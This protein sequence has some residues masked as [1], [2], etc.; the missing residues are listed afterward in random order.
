MDD[1]PSVAEMVERL[2]AEYEAARRRLCLNG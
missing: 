1:V 2:T